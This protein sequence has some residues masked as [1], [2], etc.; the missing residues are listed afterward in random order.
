MRE[1]FAYQVHRGAQ[2]S[3]DGSGAAS[4]GALVWD[5]SM[6]A[7]TRPTRAENRSRFLIRWDTGS[8]SAE[9][10]KEQVQVIPSRPQKGDGMS[11]ELQRGRAT[12]TYLPLTNRVG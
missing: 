5:L 11:W 7:N 3:S 2:K 4:P 10:R 9:P 1:A 6:A 8:S 12:D